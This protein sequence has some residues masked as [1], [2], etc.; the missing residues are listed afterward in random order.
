MTVLACVCNGRIVYGGAGDASGTP[1]LFIVPALLIVLGIA[2]WLA[3]RRH[4]LRTRSWAAGSPGGAGS[5]VE[6][7][8]AVESVEE[9]GHVG[10]VVEPMRIDAN[11]RR[12]QQ[13]DV[14]APLA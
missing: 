12:G 8:E 11:A 5:I 10:L 3:V 1:L 7:R 2:V 14:D 9:P 13:P 4:R 6:P